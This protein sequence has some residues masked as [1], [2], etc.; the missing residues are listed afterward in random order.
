[1]CKPIKAEVSPGSK[2]TLGSYHEIIRVQGL[3][4]LGSHP[5]SGQKSRRIY[6]GTCIITTNTYTN[7][8]SFTLLQAFEHGIQH[9][10]PVHAYNL[11]QIHRTT[12]TNPSQN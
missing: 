7:I 11:L 4:Q 9:M 6:M 1:M 3:D 10:I 5:G 2:R 12:Y 8:I